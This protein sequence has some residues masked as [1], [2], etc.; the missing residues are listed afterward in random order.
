MENENKSLCKSFAHDLPKLVFFAVLLVVVYSQL[1][2]C[3][4]SSDF[5]Q[6]NL[7]D[8]QEKVRRIV[9]DPQFTLVLTDDSQL[10]MW[11]APDGLSSSQIGFGRVLNGQ[12]VSYETQTLIHE[13]DCRMFLKAV[14]CKLAKMDR[15]ELFD[16]LW[17]DGERFE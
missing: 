16:C 1:T 11:C 15:L 6:L 9:G 17:V 2:A 3:G 13:G 5:R 8:D 4:L 10:W 14:A 7:G 12:L